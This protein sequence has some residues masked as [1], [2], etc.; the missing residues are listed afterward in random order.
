M[1]PF[2]IKRIFEKIVQPKTSADG[3]QGKN[4]KM[5]IS[6]A[7]GGNISGVLMAINLGADINTIDR[8]TGKTALY[9][10]VEANALPLIELLIKNKAR[11]DIPERSTKYTPIMLATELNFQRAIVAMMQSPETGMEKIDHRGRNLIN[12]ALE[13]GK[14]KVA[15]FFKDAGA[16]V[17]DAFVWAIDE[18]LVDQMNWCLEQGASMNTILPSGYSPLVKAILERNQKEVKYF[19]SKGAD[20]NWMG[21]GGNLVSTRGKNSLMIALETMGAEEIVLNLLDNPS[22]D[23]ACKDMLGENALMKAVR[24]CH[25]KAVKILIEKG[26]DQ[27]IVSNERATLLIAAAQS[28]RVEM[29]QLVW[30]LGGFNVNDIDNKGWNPLMYAAREGDLES[31]KLFLSFGADPTYRSPNLSITAADLAMGVRRRAYKET[32]ERVAVYDSIIELLTN[33]KVA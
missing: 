9:F 19:L 31:A 17:Q 24:K 6:Q 11:A 5:L 2:R 1:V 3:H 33:T 32:P 4:E 28:G 25:I 21:G 12:I 14:P 13:K 15:L 26:S 29:A 8:D 20:P 23:V 7:R 22:I 18:N 30:N 10:A 27:K 16:D